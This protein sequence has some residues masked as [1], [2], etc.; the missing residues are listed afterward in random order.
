[1]KATNKFGPAKDLWRPEA[2]QDYLWPSLQSHNE[3]KFIRYTF[4]NV[5]PGPDVGV[6]SQSYNE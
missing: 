2:S 6:D 3:T 1:M 4:V 5:S